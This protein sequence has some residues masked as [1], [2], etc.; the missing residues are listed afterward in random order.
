MY[1]VH[2]ANATVA[3]ADSQREVLQKFGVALNFPQWYGTNL[4]AFN[5]CLREFTNSLTAPFTVVWQVSSEFSKD[6]AFA[7]MSQIIEEA[8][9]QEG[10]HLSVIA[11]LK[12]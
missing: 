7:A 12:K 8:E 4:D 2:G 1:L 10:H 11:L 6:R 5:D 3:S 9:Q